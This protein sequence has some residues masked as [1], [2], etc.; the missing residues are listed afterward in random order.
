MVCDGIFVRQAPGG[1]VR[2]EPLPAPTEEEVKAILHRFAARANEL[3]RPV[4]DARCPVP[5]NSGLLPDYRPEL[6]PEI[7]PS[8]PAVSPG[9]A[10]DRGYR[11]AEGTTSHAAQRPAQ[12]RS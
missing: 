6:T 12:P 3:L 5:R 2:F 8:L 7:D 4:L 10:W 1:Q 11:L 9:R